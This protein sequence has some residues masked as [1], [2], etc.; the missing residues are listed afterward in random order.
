METIQITANN[1]IEIENGQFISSKIP[2]SIKYP[3]SKYLEQINNNWE[4]VFVN[5]I[6]NYKELGTNIP[7]IRRPDLVPMIIGKNGVN[8]KGLKC[9]L[10]I[11]KDGK[12]YIFGNSEEELDEYVEEF[13]NHVL[14]IILHH[15]LKFE[16][17]EEYEEKE[18]PPSLSLE[19]MYDIIENDSSRWNSKDKRWE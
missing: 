11:E 6:K 8:L 16:D 13:D 10:I 1:T 12:F 3:I 19:E 18:K 17:C 5:D 7:E 14:K 9:P 4:C 2:T 15:S